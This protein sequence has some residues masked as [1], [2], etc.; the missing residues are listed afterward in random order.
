MM[1]LEPAPNW[2]VRCQF[3]FI[4]LLYTLQRGSVAVRR[5]RSGFSSHGLKPQDE[6][7]YNGNAY[8]GYRSLQVQHVT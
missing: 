7:I 1:K 8:G 3:N 5:V 2:Q 4:I 6:Q